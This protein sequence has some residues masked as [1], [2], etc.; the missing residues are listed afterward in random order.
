MLSLTS[1]VLGAGSKQLADHHS[2]KGLPTEQSTSSWEYG[3]LKG[4]LAAEHR[5]DLEGHTDAEGD[6]ISLALA[7]HR[8][9][10][11]DLSQPV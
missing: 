1:L 7:R 3:E 2:L 6:S 8:V 9:T 5:N 10:S 11:G 4:A